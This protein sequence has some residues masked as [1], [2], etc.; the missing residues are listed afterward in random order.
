M[1]RLT[2]PVLI[3]HGATDAE[4][5]CTIPLHPNGHQLGPQ[6]S[7]GVPLRT[8]IGPMSGPPVN[9]RSPPGG[10][11][12]RRLAH[13]SLGEP[14]QAM[15][16]AMTTIQTKVVN[17]AARMMSLGPTRA[18]LVRPTHKA[19]AHQSAASMALAVRPTRSSSASRPVKQAACQ[20]PWRQST[21]PITALSVGLSRRAP[22]LSS[23]T[24]QSRG[25]EEENRAI[26]RPPERAP[27][28]KR[29]KRP[30]NDMVP[31]D[32]RLLSVATGIR[33][34]KLI[35]RGPIQRPSQGHRAA[36]QR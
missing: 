16:S 34:A 20:I 24:S 19:D 35:N 1:Q 11:L 9:P 12:S 22:M 33:S 18:E 30:Q 13:S 21:H 6:S 10:A 29:L 25:S 8:G 23:H 3:Q 28:G 26:I 4:D 7:P 15:K 2:A 17:S 27:C 5:G 14:D 36:P 32:V 31:N